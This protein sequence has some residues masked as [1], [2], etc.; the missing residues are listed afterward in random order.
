MPLAD[1]REELLT[2][3]DPTD[4]NTPSR[5]R[6]VGSL[7]ERQRLLTSRNIASMIVLKMF[8]KNIHRARKLKAG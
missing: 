5:R 8:N 3:L 7:K 1:V 2:S 6:V 4:F